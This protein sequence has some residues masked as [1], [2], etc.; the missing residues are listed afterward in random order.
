[1]TSHLRN[2]EIFSMNPT[3]SKI[4]A[5][6]TVLSLSVFSSSGQEAQPPAD[7]LLKTARF[8]ATLQHQDLKGHIRKNEIKFPVGLYMRGQDI[9]LSYTQPEGNKDVRFHMRL[10]EKHYDLFE[11]EGGKTV[12]FPEAKLSKAI[13]GTDLSYEDLAMRFLYWPNGIVD[14]IQEIKG[15]ECWIV[16]LVNPT[17]TGRYAQVRVWVHKKSQALIQVVGYNAGGRPLK[18]FTVTDVM[19]VGDAYTLRRMRVDTVDP[20]GNRVV[21]MTYLEFDKPKATGPRPGGLR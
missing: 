2:C 6:T 21:G 3:P 8:V 17:Q 4:F 19:K 18:R 5:L 16:R 7:T 1:M 20:V 10:N 9:Q 11:L 12:R 14:G 15:Q 13:E